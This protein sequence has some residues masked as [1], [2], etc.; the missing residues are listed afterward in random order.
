MFYR[1]FYMHLSRALPSAVAAVLLYSEVPGAS[2]SDV[3]GPA[4]LMLLLGTVHCQIV[5]TE[6]SRGSSGS[7]SSSSSTS[8]ARRK[9]CF[10]LF[11]Y[12]PPS[13]RS[14]RRHNN[15]VPFLRCTSLMY[16]PVVGWGKAEDWKNQKKI[17]SETGTQSTRGPGH[18]TVIKWV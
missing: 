5:S 2:A 8:P 17:A 18:Y 10:S 1:R 3:L 11:R 6:S 16:S 9:R 7:P 15:N 4:C 13:Y 12:F 14:A